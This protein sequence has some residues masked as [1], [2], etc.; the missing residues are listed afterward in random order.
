MNSKQ[1][2]LSVF[3]LVAIVQLYVPAK[4]I[5]DREDVL[6]TGT[7][8]KFRTA[9]IDPTD[10][11]RGKYIVLRYEDNSISVKNGQEWTDGEPIYVLF[12]TDKEGF[13]QIKSVSREQPDQDHAYL[14]TT[15]DY[16]AN[17]NTEL[18][19]DYPF[20]RYYMEESKAY[21]AEQTYRES[22]V[23]STQVAY[24]LVN[25]KEGD[26]VLRDVLIDGVPIREIVKKNLQDKE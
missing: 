18:V 3:I 10:P 1:I 8:Y 12:K 6:S 2:L 11:F 9:P 7:A 15:V 20:D 17:I 23:D 24:A 5:W 13:A 14:L 16:I 21:E 4:M 22:Q 19:I 25:I 26:A